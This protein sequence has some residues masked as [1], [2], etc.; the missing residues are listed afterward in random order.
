MQAR[1]VLLILSRLS[2]DGESPQYY[3]IN[4]MQPRDIVSSSLTA[5][6]RG[7]AKMLSKTSPCKYNTTR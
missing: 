6:G 4:I 5:A 1:L 7:K 2:R 3:L